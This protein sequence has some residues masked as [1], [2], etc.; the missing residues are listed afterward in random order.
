MK[1]TFLLITVLAGIICLCLSASCTKSDE[2]PD[3]NS[4]TGLTVV[5][6]EKYISAWNETDSIKRIAILK[7]VFAEDGFH[8]SAFDGSDGLQGLSQEIGRSKSRF[9]GYTYSSDHH[10]TMSNY[11]FWIWRMYDTN[12]DLFIWGYDFGELN[13]DGKLKKVIGFAHP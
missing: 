4:K 9:A 6:I 2:S 7:D 5:F 8:V 13:D 11:G 1:S 10:I 12:K 3:K